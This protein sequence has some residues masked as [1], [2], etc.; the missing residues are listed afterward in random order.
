MF[1]ATLRMAGRLLA[2]FLILSA[3]LIA[4]FKVP[5]LHAAFLRNYVGSR[6]VM[7]TN[8]EG[9]SGGTGFHIKAPS[10]QT[11]IVTN[12]HV[13]EVA[14]KDVIYAA[15]D[16]SAP[17][18]RR[19][20]QKSDF[21]DLC[22]VEPVPGVEGLSVGSEP[23]IGQIVAELGHP[24]LSPLITSR[25]EIVGKSEVE[26]LTGVIGM[27]TKREDCQRPKNRIR[28][29]D[30]GFFSVEACFIHVEA[31]NSSIPTYPG[32]SGSPIV[33]ELG[34]VVGVIFAGSNRSGY[35]LAIPLDALNDFIKHY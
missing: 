1:K 9:N 22:L 2:L 19:V 25:G 10:G 13:C 12:D 7:L 11:Y 27:D 29:V 35:G 23:Y 24:E 20:I 21:T 17:I 34:R 26:V 5:V 30:L 14:D 33:D 6:V 4:G 31:Y 3:A 28:Q 18:P 32:N 16:N 15:F 8:K